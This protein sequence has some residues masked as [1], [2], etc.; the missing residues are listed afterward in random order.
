MTDELRIPSDTQL[1]F[2]TIHQQHLTKEF[3]YHKQV[4][5]A[6]EIELAWVSVV[7]VILIGI[8]YYVL[9]RLRKVEREDNGHS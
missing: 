2:V 8:D 6:H 9:M 4:L 5:K 3:D 1:K 7:L